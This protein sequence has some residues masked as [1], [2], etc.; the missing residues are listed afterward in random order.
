[1]KDYFARLNPLERRFVIG[2]GVVVF[3]IIN[4]WWVRPHFGD[5]KKTQDRLTK[6]RDTLQMYEAEIQKMGIYQ[7]QVK[8]LESEG[9]NVP[10]ED[11]D[12]QLL[13][14]IQTQAA[15]SGVLL[16]QTGPQTTRTND[17]FFLEKHQPITVQAGEKQLVDFLHNLGSGNSLIRVRDLAVRPDAP[18]HQLNATIKL[19]ASYQKKPT[20][21]PAAS[22]PAK[23]AATPPPA[24]AA[25]T[26]SATT[27]D[28]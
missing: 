28:K 20:A 9:L 13:R 10:L 8:S 16:T 26:P 6:A 5:W 23:T 19:V 21:R 3:I 22:A 17:Q 2:V 18:R 4:L 7:A 24:T 15:R 11:Q 25:A 14:A 12:I 1:M 27:T